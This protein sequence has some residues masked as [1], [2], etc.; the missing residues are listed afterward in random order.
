M[1]VGCA[2]LLSSASDGVPSWAAEFVLKG[3]VNVF[4]VLV[5]LELAGAAAAFDLV[6]VVSKVSLLVLLV[7]AWAAAGPS[8]TNTE[9]VTCE[10]ALVGA[11]ALRC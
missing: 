10:L 6:N 11:E 9:S 8:V 2:V 5:H 3:A 7:L 1:V 4:L